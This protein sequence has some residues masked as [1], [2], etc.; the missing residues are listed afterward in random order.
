MIEFEVIPAIDLLDGECVRLV[1]GKPKAKTTYSGDAASVALAFVACGARTLHVID[2]NAALGNGSNAPAV[3]AI[4]KAVRGKA[5]V[6]VGGG[7]RDARRAKRLFSLGADRVMVGT[8]A[9]TPELEKITRCGETLAAIDYTRGAIQVKGWT[10]QATKMTLEV[11]R[12]LED[13]GVAGFLATDVER[14][15]TLKGTRTGTLETLVAATRL[16][17]YA[18]GG[19]AALDDVRETARAGAAGV[20]VGKALYE[21]KFTL[22]QALEVAEQC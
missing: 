10:S 12:T 17:V 19:V 3:R 20:I 22:E 5:R 15:G 18:A 8:A 2:L 6:Q 4:I 14:D 13:Q 1:K 11:L 21:G 9:F 7:I 16:P